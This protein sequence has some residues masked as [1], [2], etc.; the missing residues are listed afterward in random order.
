[1]TLMTHLTTKC[2]D[3]VQKPDFSAQCQSTG[4]A[5]GLRFQ[6]GANRGEGNRPR[7]RPVVGRGNDIFVIF[8]S[9]I[10]RPHNKCCT[11]AASNASLELSTSRLMIQGCA[12]ITAGGG[13]CAAE[14]R[15]GYSGGSVSRPRAEW[16]KWSFGQDEKSCLTNLN[17]ETSIISDYGILRMLWRWA[18]KHLL[19]KS[20]KICHFFIERG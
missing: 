16:S 18:F 9:A 3:G 10:R 7:F 13:G 2:V 15:S 20:H 5:A 6:P 19:L 12:H 1:M 11:F 14:E 17:A 4:K 8:V